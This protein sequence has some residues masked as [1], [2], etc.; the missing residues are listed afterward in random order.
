MKLLIEVLGNMY[1]DWDNELFRWDTDNYLKLTLEGNTVFSG[2][3]SQLEQSAEFQYVLESYAVKDDA[4]DSVT[5]EVE[6]LEYYKLW[7]MLSLSSKTELGDDLKLGYADCDLI[8]S[9]ETSVKY[10]K[11]HL[12]KEIEVGQGFKFSDLAFVRLGNIADGIPSGKPYFASLISCVGYGEIVLREEAS[13][14]KDQYN[15][16]IPDLND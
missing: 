3:F 4:F 15:C 8:R 7:E 13:N 6:A 2:Q 14:I 5:N 1:Q 9:G 12:K 11:Y 16:T 10:G